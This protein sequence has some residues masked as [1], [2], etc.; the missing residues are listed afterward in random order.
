M[1]TRLGDRIPSY[2]RQFWII[3]AGGLIGSSGGSMV[4][5]F[6]FLFM[7]ERLDVPLAEVGVILGM[8]SLSG[9]VAQPLAGS[10]VDRFGRKWA[11]LFSLG[12]GALT[13]VGFILSSSLEAYLLLSLLAGATWPVGSVATQ[14]MV[15]DMIPSPRRP[16]AF[17]ILRIG[18]NVGFALGPAVGGFLAARS[19]S[20]S[21]AAAA[22][23]S[24]VILVLYALTVKETMPAAAEGQIGRGGDGGYRRVLRDTPFLSFAFGYG[25]LGIAYMPMLGLLAVTLKE[26]HAIPESG[27]G[28]LMTLNGLMVVLFQLPVTSITERFPPLPVMATGAFLVAAGVGAVAYVSTLPLFAAAM[29]VFTIGELVFVPTSATIAADLAPPEMRGRYM[30]VRDVSWGA[31]RAVGPAGAGAL[32]DLYGPA[33]MWQGAMAVGLGS[34]GVFALLWTRAVRAREAGGLPVVGE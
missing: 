33:A 3:V 16:R 20:Y 15:A 29:V 24:T 11:M 30:A 9:F 31:S 13:S 6:L 5:P 19:F 1:R 28:L 23:A 22:T 27:F 2:P 4:W 17:A 18:H 8:S 21:F 32:N 10:L 26:V 25:L 12:G 7:R 14:A 34:A